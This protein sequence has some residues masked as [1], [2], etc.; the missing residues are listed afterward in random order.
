MIFGLRFLF[1]PSTFLLFGVF[2]PLSSSSSFLL[3]FNRSVFYLHYL[4]Y[5]YFF[6]YILY[7]NA[8]QFSQSLKNL[9]IIFDHTLSWNECVTN[10]SYRVFKF[11]YQFK[12]SIDCLPRFMRKLLVNSQI[13]PTIDYCYQTAPMHRCVFTVYPSLYRP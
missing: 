8:L 11:A 6:S 12:K 5:F 1:F 7:G 13:S 4:F 10:I 3:S 2:L 9:G